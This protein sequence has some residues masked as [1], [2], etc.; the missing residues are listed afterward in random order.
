MKNILIIFLL[1]FVFSL[2]LMPIAIKILKKISVSQTI[3]GYVENHKEKNGTTTMGGVVFLIITLII[4]F[5]CLK[6]DNEWF[7]VVL[8]SVFFGILGFMDDFLK[9]KLKQNLGLR[10]YQKIIGQV[11]IAIIFAL[12]IY[13]SNIGSNIYLPFSQ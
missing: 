10:P 13:F 9:V 6:Y 1:G 2:I 3:L 7:V 5:F 11:G 12:F 8:V 4:P